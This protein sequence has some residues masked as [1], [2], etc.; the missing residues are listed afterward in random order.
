MKNTMIFPL[1][2]LALSSEETEEQFI[3]SAWN[4][5]STLL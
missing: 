2:I 3:V 4:Q 5:V 1:I